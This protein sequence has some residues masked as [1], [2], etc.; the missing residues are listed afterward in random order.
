MKR[1]YLAVVAIAALAVA[2]GSTA[3]AGPTA[4]GSVLVT[5]DKSITRTHEGPF[6]LV[7]RSNADTVYLSEAELQTGQCRF[8]I[9]TNRGGTWTKGGS[10]N[11]APY[12]CTPGTG[13]PQSIR[14]NLAQASNGT[15]L[16][17][18]AG[19]DPAAG[20]SRSI[21]LGRSSDKGNSW[22]T[23]LVYA[24]PK[25]TTDTFGN[26]ELNYQ[27]HLA[28]DPANANNVFV[29]WRRA[30]PN[31]QGKV[32]LPNRPWM[33]T[34]TDGGATFGQ[35]FKPMD[36]DT[37]SDSPYIF[38]A[39][40]VLTATFMVNPPRPATGAAPPQE[41]HLGT[42]SDSGK[43]WTDSKI[44]SANFVDGPNAVYDAAAKRY[45]VVWDDNRNGEFDA[46]YSSSTDGTTWADPKKLNDDPKRVKGH[47]FPTISAAPNAGRLNVAW[48]DFRNDPYPADTGPFA[49][50]QGKRSDVYATSSTDSGKTWSA[51]LRVN[52][53]V[54]DR[55]KG[56]QN[57]QYSFFVPLSAVS[58]SDWMLTAWSD[59]RNGD[60]F[61]STQDIF[62]GQL[63][64]NQTVAG[65]DNGSFATALTIA[66]IGGIGGG[67]G[68]ALLIA[69]AVLRR[70]QGSVGQPSTP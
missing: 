29:I 13:H 1:Q 23:T 65:G 35:P 28:V 64:F 58:G 66:V 14:T 9:S 69:V 38:F 70:R 49:G 33:A 37:G 59:T 40:G 63:L 24:A 3:T 5:N 8:Y 44:S 50:D 56:I 51:N 60:S 61:S 31:F 34:S 30:Y 27:A 22:Q 62:T 36:K 57:P 7:D 47:L 2:C 54:I 18:F 68:V 39:K 55:T 11:L 4:Q 42:S 10:P 43:T 16:Y 25:V 17:G 67:A 48:Y 46:F 21:L 26:A 12:N 19:N 41:V 52:N 53:Q 45:S 20:G 15:L 6:L 32:F